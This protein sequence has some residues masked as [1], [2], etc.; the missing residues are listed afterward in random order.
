MNWL[1]HLL[2][3]DPEETFRI[4]NLLPDLMPMG[5]LV[6]LPAE[7]QRGIQRHREIDAFT[8]SHPVFRRS[9]QRFETPYRRF[10]GVLV[11][12]FYDHFLAN[13]W[14]EYSET[15]LPDFA[16]EVYASFEGVQHI[17][18]PEIVAGLRQMQATNLLCS[19]SEVSGISGALQRISSRLKRPVELAPAV[20]VLERHYGAFHEDFREFFPTLLG[21]W[22]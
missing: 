3:S 20:A 7:Y 21:R 15:T 9:T 4:G 12:L 17:L 2:L 10:G 22:R 18:P 1:A 14:A 13:N 11:D 5:Q 6:H 16:A 8:D 19:Y